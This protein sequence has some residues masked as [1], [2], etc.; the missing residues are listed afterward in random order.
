MA[1]YRAE[2]REPWPTTFSGGRS[3]EDAVARLYGVDGVGPSYLI[4]GSGNLVGIYY[5]PAELEMK[6][7]ELVRDSKTPV[8]ESEAIR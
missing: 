6:L 5:D 2:M 1:S 3:W 7:A 4:D 8:H